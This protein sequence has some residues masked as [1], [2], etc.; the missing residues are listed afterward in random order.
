MGYLSNLLN[1]LMFRVLTIL[2][3]CM[4]LFSCS[5]NTYF[6][7]FNTTDLPIHV[8]YES[9]GLT[10]GNAF[11]IDPIILSFNSRYAIENKSVQSIIVIDSLTNSVQCELKNG[12]ALRIGG[13]FNFTLSNI[14]EAEILKN[15]LI[16][17][18]ISQEEKELIRA[19]SSNI[20]SFFETI[21]IHTVGIVVEN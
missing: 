5:Y 17:L 8:I 16:Q 15:N 10:Y 4:C 2:F 21:D 14:G 7:I 20:I 13:D 19:D 6:Y 12:E 1:R 18:T 9:K 11:R 3:C